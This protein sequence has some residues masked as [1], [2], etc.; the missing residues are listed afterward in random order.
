MVQS[1]TNLK[2]GHKDTVNFFEL[3]EFMFEVSHER[4]IVFELF[5]CTRNHPVFGLLSQI[6][7]HSVHTFDSFARLLIPHS[8]VIEHL[9]ANSIKINYHQLVRY[10]HVYTKNRLYT[11][12]SKVSRQYERAYSSRFLQYLTRQLFLRRK[13]RGW[14]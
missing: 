7:P 12:C 2:K 8:S 9:S 13:F 14:S 6:S 10:T 11:E 1:Y 4:R 3:S 5:M